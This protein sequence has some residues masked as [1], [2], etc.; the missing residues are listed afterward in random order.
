M[1]TLYKIIKSLQ[2]AQGSL[3]KQ[4]ILDANKDNELLKSFMQ[5][6]YDPAISYYQKA[7][8]KHGPP[9]GR[10]AAFDLTD[11]KHAKWTFAER[12]AT[13]DEAKRLMKNWLEDQ[14]SVEDQELCTL[15]IKRS[16]GASVGDTMILKTWPDLYF[17]PPYMRC[18]LADDKIKAKFG[19]RDTILVQPKL[20]GSFCYLVKEVNKP[21]EAITRAGSKYPQW[22]A[23][24]LATGVPDGFVGIGEI[25]VFTAAEGVDGFLLPRQQGN[26][27]LN[28][29]LK[30]GDEEKFDRLQFKLTCWDML[31]P[32]EFKVGKST[33]VYKERMATLFMQYD[34]NEPPN[35]RVIRS[36]AVKNLDEAYKIYSEYTSEGMEGAV[37]K[38][39]DGIWKDGTSKDNV[40]LKIAFEAEYIVTAVY[41][42]E[43]KAKG[44]MGGISVETS[45]GLLKSNCG[46][47]FT[48]AQRKA[49][50]AVGSIVTLIANDVISNRD[51]DCKSLFLPIYSDTRFDK[52]KADSLQRVMEQLQAAKGIKEIK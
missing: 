39:P 40:K 35:I 46:S 33:R 19:A 15:M 6:T 37:I 23:D 11:I 36:K 1:T 31:T 16:I 44:M 50:I 26:G 9:S 52:T 43:G 4:A 20:D 41:E 12:N 3:A 28:S 8:P 27:F 24:K 17:Q 14:N 45:D 32:E 38:N 42:G 29:V 7:V 49:G 25:E 47:G 5:A 21:A 22:F 34:L 30:E 13:G 18:S 51:N 2:N 10:Q 48:D